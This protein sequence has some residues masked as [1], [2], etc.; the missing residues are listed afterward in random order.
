MVEEQEVNNQQ[1][2]EAYLLVPSK[3]TNT[4]GNFQFVAENAPEIWG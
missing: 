1:T 2:Y 4:M 3:S